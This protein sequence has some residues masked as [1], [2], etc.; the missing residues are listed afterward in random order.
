M[1]KE[2]NKRDKKKKFLKYFLGII[3]VFFLIFVL[4]FSDLQDMVNRIRIY[5]N[6]T[7]IQ[8]EIVSIIREKEAKGRGA[9]YL[10]C[11]A[12]DIFPLCKRVEELSGN[13]PIVEVSEGI[14]FCAYVKIKEDNYFCVDWTF[15]QEISVHPREGGYCDG[16]NFS[17]LY[18][19]E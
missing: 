13:F 19:K 7:Q 16:E 18:P 1:K 9:D 17:C 5:Y 4:L 12:K 3:G 14:D 6:M 15:N 10:D 11:T 2:E 8:A